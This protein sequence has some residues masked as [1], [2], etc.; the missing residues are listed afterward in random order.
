VS[1]R[2]RTR[3]SSCRQRSRVSLARMSEG[4]H[5]MRL[6]PSQCPISP[7]VALPP[8]ARHTHTCLAQPTT[9][10]TTATI[11]WVYRVPFV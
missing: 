5:V 6:R 8:G 3:S 9:P 11:V 4:V 1:E 7:P 10:V 2:E